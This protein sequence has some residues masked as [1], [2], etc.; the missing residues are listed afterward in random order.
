MKAPDD[1][2]GTCGIPWLSIGFGPE[3]QKMLT[4][5][6]FPISEFNSWLKVCCFT[7]SLYFSEKLTSLLVISIGLIRPVLILPVVSLQ[8][9]SPLSAHM[10]GS[11]IT[12]PYR[13]LHA[14][15]NEVAFKCE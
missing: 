1:N 15:A 2:E 7:F 5:Q 4:Y 12:P 11:R 6:L 8:L 3:M 9:F 14:A 10:E 13:F